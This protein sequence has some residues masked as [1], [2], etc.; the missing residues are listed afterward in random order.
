MDTQVHRDMENLLAE[1]SKTVSREAIRLFALIVNRGCSMDL[2]QSDVD[3]PN[4]GQ[5]DA[6]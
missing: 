6:E 4:A 5:Y 3:G 2:V 1:R